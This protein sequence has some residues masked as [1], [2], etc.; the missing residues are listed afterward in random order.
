MLDRGMPLNSA[1]TDREY[2]QAEKFCRIFS[3]TVSLLVALGVVLVTARGVNAPAFSL[4]HRGICFMNKV[5]DI[6]TIVFP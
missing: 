1:A 5:I 3:V 6:Q 4:V 2:R